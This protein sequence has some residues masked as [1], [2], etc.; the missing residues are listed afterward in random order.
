MSIL[1]VLNVYFL[2]DFRENWRRVSHALLTEV[3]EFLSV[4]L[5]LM[6][7]GIA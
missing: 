2:I 1:V 7:V 3:N 6:W 4:R 5:H